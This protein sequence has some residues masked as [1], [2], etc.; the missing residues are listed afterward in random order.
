MEFICSKKASLCDFLMIV[1]VSSTHLFH[2]IGV[3]GD[4]ARALISRSSMNKSATMGL[5]GDPVA[6]PSICSNNL[7]LEGEICSS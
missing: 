6:A 5:I 7:T 3:Y 4:V 1:K 2:S